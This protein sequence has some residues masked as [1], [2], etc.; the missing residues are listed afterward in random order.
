M[1]SDLPARPPLDRARLA[2]APAGN[3]VEVVDAAPSTNALAAQRARAGAAEG[4]V[5]VAEH[6]TAGRGRLDRTWETPDR[7]A[8]TFTVLLRPRLDAARWPWLPLLVGHAVARALRA[9]GHDARLK[10]PNDVLLGTDEKKVAGILVER[11]DTPGGPAALAGVGL[12][13]STAPGELPVETAT[14][15]MIGSGTEPDRTELLLAIL[16]T[17]REEYDAWQSGGSRAGEDLRTAYLRSC[18]TVGQDVRVELPGSAPLL[19]RATGL[20]AGGRL[21]V[22]GPGGE[23]VVGAGDVVHVR[24]VVT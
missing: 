7:A 2:A 12:N 24:P 5:V 6:Q 22:Q 16:Q 3:T 21:V 18:V 19:G 1:T 14:S 10:W 23:V 9:A 17:V 15:L 8:L 13:V 11:I 20:D 4:L